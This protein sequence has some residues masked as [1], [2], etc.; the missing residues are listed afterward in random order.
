M[1][2][3]PSVILRSQTSVY[4]MPVGTCVFRRANA[5]LAT[6]QPRKPAFFSYVGKSP[7]K[8]FVDEVYDFWSA[9]GS[10]IELFTVHKSP[11]LLRVPYYAIDDTCYTANESRAMRTFVDSVRRNPILTNTDR[12]ALEDILI[13][14]L[15]SNEQS[16]YWAI[17][18]VC[19][20]G[21]D[22]WIRTKCAKDPSSA[23]EIAICKNWED[24]LVKLPGSNSHKCVPDIFSH[25]TWNSRRRQRRRRRPQK[26]ARRIPSTISFR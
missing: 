6:R 10:L 20:L 17:D 13:D 3:L 26:R 7:T 18:A 1:G 24:F 4:Q 14:G 19:K 8:A 12:Q 9:H 11:R 23:D 16:D 25:K 21:Y 22:G 2:L 15:G 5:P